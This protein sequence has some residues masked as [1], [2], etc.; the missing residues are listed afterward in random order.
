MIKKGGDKVRGNK[1]QKRE[2]N[3]KNRENPIIFGLRFTIFDSRNW[4]EGTEGSGNN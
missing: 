2:L 1:S 3:T 4:W